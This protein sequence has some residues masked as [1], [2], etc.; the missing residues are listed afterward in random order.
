ME[1]AVSF[2]KDG[3]T[4]GNCRKRQF[5]QKGRCRGD[6]MTDDYYTLTPPA[7]ACSCSF[8]KSTFYTASDLLPQILRWFSIL[9]SCT[10]LQGAALTSWPR[11]EQAFMACTLHL[12]IGAI[13]SGIA[14]GPPV[15][16]GSFSQTQR[17]LD[18]LSDP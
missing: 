4:C 8:L 15:R 1:G 17:C 5:L 13:P 12:S 16:E 3:G 14:F 9:M 2:L 6:K 7:V 10:R 11:P 18:L